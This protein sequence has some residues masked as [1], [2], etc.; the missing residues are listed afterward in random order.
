MKEASRRDLQQ[1]FEAIVDESHGEVILDGQAF[2]LIHRETIADLQ[3]G[4]EEILGRGAETVLLRAGYRRGESLASRLTAMVGG[5]ETPFVDGLRTFAA[6]TGL[7][8]I[9]AVSIEPPQVTFRVTN[10]FIARGYGKATRPVCHYLRGF[11][12][13]AGEQLRRRTQL[14]CQERKCSATGELECVFQVSPLPGNRDEGA[15][16]EGA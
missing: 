10:S 8:R 6:R 1:A 13:A 3:H 16:G 11:L 4:M 9:E 5:L 15:R 12:L 7:C 2:V 14:E